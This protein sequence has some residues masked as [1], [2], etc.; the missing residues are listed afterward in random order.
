MNQHDKNRKFLN[1]YKP[2][3]DGSLADTF[4][5]NAKKSMDEYD[6][7]TEEQKTILRAEYNVKMKEIIK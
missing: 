1:E 2:K 4:A 7:M 3:N 6:A 5:I